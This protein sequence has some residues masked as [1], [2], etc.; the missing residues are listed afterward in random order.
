MDIEIQRYQLVL[1]LPNIILSLLLVSVSWCL[2]FV[3]VNFCLLYFLVGLVYCCWFDVGPIDFWFN[4][5]LAWSIVSLLH[6][7]L[8]WFV[9]FVNYWVFPWFGLLLLLFVVGLV[10]WFVVSLIF[11]SSLFGLHINNLFMSDHV[12]NFLYFHCVVVACFGVLVWC[13]FDLLSLLFFYI[14][15]EAKLLLCTSSVRTCLCTIAQ[16]IS[17]EGWSLEII[18]IDFFEI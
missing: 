8:V 11:G 2:L 9:Q 14:K 3:D 1:N 10:N 12:L 15:K 7:G 13:C 17:F 5:L 6:F 18:V 4:L 16:F